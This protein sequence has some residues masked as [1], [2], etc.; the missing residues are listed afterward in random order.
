MA[1]LKFDSK[2]IKT[3]ENMVVRIIQDEIRRQDLIDTGLMLRSV[4]A[5][6][7]IRGNSFTIDVTSTEY[8]K[9]VDGN[10]NIV[11]NAFNSR[12]YQTL[13]VPAIQDLFVKA[14]ESI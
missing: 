2:G 12:D 4:K 10:Y 11:N 7:N 14:F 3:V 6:L 9:Y 5:K 8:F 1:K 13:V